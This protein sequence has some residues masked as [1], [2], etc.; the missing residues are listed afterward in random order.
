LFQMFV[1]MTSTEL[2]KAV[3]E[4]NRLKPATSQDRLPP[5]LDQAGAAVASFFDH[6]PDTACTEHVVS[7]VSGSGCSDSCTTITTTTTWPWLNRAL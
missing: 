7:S 3:P 5:N 1:D 2:N 4:L 6:F